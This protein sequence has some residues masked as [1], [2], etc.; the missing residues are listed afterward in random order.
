MLPQRKR[1]EVMAA[2]GADLT[3]CCGA[4]VTAVQVEFWN[5]H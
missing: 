2:G 1:Q 4:A 5:W 3:A